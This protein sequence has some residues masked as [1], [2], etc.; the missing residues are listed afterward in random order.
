MGILRPLMT[1]KANNIANRESISVSI[2]FPSSQKK[3]SEKGKMR[4]E[5]RVGKK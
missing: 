2:F 3:K 1:L 5:K 4:E